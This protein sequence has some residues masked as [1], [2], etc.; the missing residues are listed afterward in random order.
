MSFAHL[1][2]EAYVHPLLGL[3]GVDLVGF[4]DPDK[5]RGAEMAETFGLHHFPR[6][7]DLLAEGLDGVLVCSENAGG[8]ELVELAAAAGAH[9]L[10]ESRSRSL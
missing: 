3:S 9:V 5:Q 7:E 6:H 8:R 2:A 1:H 10:C 4:S